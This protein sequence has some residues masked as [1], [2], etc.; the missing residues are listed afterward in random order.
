MSCKVV[1]DNSEQIKSQINLLT[2]EALEEIA[3]LVESYAARNTRVATGKTKASWQHYVEDNVATVG[4]TEENAIWEEYGTGEYALNGNGRKGKWYVAI[5]YG[6]NQ[7]TPSTAEKYHFKI[8][9]GKNG[10]QYAEV[11]GKTPTR[12]L[13]KALTQAKPLVER[14]FKVTF[15]IMR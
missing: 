6:K 13:Y 9:Y 1:K 2:S 7:M 8:V 11:S 14:T 3:G 10:M 5:G 12:A 15:S 4:N